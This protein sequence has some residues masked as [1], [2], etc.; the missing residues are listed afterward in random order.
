MSDA[1][2]GRKKR[3]WVL[4]LAAFAVFA[5][6]MAMLSAFTLSTWGDLST[7]EAPQARR[8][9]SQALTPLGP[10]PPYIEVSRTGTV[11]V[12][13]DQE[14]AEPSELAS[15][16]MLAYD[17]ASSRLVDIAFPFW[18]VRL[19]MSRTFNLANVTS[20]VLGDWDNLDLTVTEDDLERRGP[21]LVL[22]HTTEDGKRI[23]L[24]TEGPD[25]KAEAR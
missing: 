15:L 22:D 3:R 21:G 24:W 25:E 23:V 18:F 10:R 2:G 6:V 16:R 11:R 4:P 20:F 9:F 8:I 12:N 5:V 1:G 17:P 13:R 14:A 7:V 19:K